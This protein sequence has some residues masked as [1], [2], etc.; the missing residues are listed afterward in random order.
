[1]FTGFLL[2]AHQLFLEGDHLQ[3]A[4]DDH[5]LEFLEVQDLFLTETARWADVVLPGSSFAEKVGT[6]VNTERRIQLA[7]A[8][9]A[10][11]GDARVDLDIL[12]DLSKRLGLPTDFTGPEAAYD[13]P[14]YWP[15][16]ERAE[17]YGMIIIF[18]TGIVSSEAL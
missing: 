4:A 9:L 14:R 1:M 12:I 18:H 3:L 15:I 5:F 17:K 6:F 11:P 10:P 8:A 2:Q 13:D 16:Y 7:D